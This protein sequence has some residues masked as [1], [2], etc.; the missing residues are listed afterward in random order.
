[1][2]NAS[3]LTLL[4]SAGVAFAQT[5]GTTLCTPSA[6]S[7]PIFSAV[8]TVGTV[9]DY[10]LS[11]VN[12]GF[13]P[14]TP[15]GTVRFDFF[16]NTSILNPATWT[17]VQGLNSYTGSL[18]NSN[19]VDFTGITYDPNLSNVNFELEGVQVNPSLWGAGFEYR[20]TIAISGTI[21]LP[22]KNNDPVVTV[23]FNDNAPEP[24]TLFLA[25]GASLL[26]FLKRR[27]VAGV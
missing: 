4:F 7:V 13:S 10:L 12:S 20:E 2:K 3:L 5:P 17:L 15:S 9:G 16:A 24:G 8:S 19:Q 21:S 26:L 22:I 18:T 11:C 25:G 23:A 14:G 27:R 1:M 6:A